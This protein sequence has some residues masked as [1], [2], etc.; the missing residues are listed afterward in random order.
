MLGAGHG[1][2]EHDNLLGPGIVS[3]EQGDQQQREAPH[4]SAD[5]DRH[6]VWMKEFTDTTP[7]TERADA[8]NC[9]VFC[10]EATTPTR[11]T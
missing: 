2:P 4:A 7:L 10:G 11:T 9:C 6:I 1:R 3:E 8:T 5:Q